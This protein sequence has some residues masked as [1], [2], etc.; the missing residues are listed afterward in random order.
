MDKILAY[1][2]EFGFTK[3]T[4]TLKEAWRLSIHGISGAIIE[5]LQNPHF[6][7]NFG[8]D[9]HFQEDPMAK[10]GLIEAKNHRDR[11]IPLPMFLALY[12]YY[13]QTYIDFLET[14][15][16]SNDEYQKAEY[17]INRA[18]NRMEIGYIAEWNSDKEST[19]L[20]NLQETNRKMT[21]EKN[22]YLTMFSSLPTPIAILD[23]NHQIID[24][25]YQFESVFLGSQIPGKHYYDETNKKI[26]MSH[27]DWLVAEVKQF[28]EFPQKLS[29]L[30]KKIDT[31][32]G[33]RYFLISFKE[34]LDVSK[35]ITG[36]IVFF[37]DRTK[38][39]EIQLEKEKFETNL[40]QIQKLESLGILAGGIA[41]DF[42]NLLTGIL[43]NAELAEM[44]TD[45]SK[46]S[47]Y[48]EEIIQTAQSARKLTSNLLTYSGKDHPKS[49][50]LD[51]NSQIS[52]L[53]SLIKLS[54]NKKSILELNLDLEVP[55]IKGDP[56]QIN[57]I[58]LNLVS[59]AS[60]AFNDKV[61]TIKIS[62]YITEEIPKA[63][64][65]F[66]FNEGKESQFIVL[67]VS[68]NGCGIPLDIQERIFDPF[69]TTKFQGRGLGLAVVLGNVK[70]HN[71]IIQIDSE[72]GK[73][74][75][76]RIYFPLSEHI[77]SYISRN[78]KPITFKNILSRLI[79][80]K[81]LVIDDEYVVLKTL[82]NVLLRHQMHVTT[83]ENGLKAIEMVKIQPFHFDY[84]FLDL[85]MPVIDGL[86]VLH[87][88]RKINSEVPVIL[89]S[90]YSVKNIQTIK[91]Q[92]PNVY[93]LQKPFKMD[94]ILIVFQQIFENIQTIG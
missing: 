2:L 26:E 63:N 71:G 3:Y 68:D 62:T 47:P 66:D 58:I 90:G 84:I 89:I 91:L 61:G 64:T 15:D 67:E 22:K 55:N 72:V 29:L 27:W 33:D 69:F 78:S 39:H 16:F 53:H 12:K 11:G 19:L 41:H 7:I 35:K 59:N 37:L 36:T 75:T 38:E 28:Y 17:F 60:D 1:A 10:F 80:L 70:T 13:N 86:D 8:P 40:H 82:E 25:N 79:G 92:D 6:N 34:L 76:F 18:F 51:L 94:E 14:C 21:N 20:K 24:V 43:G 77:S 83:E 57:Q 54:I 31:K 44:E 87:R 46:I 32:G 81:V 73:G 9:E 88:I 52:E 5:S 49:Q 65:L 93:F 42:N 50:P 4:S 23:E 56:S 74:T 30:D 45:D 85:T 48:L